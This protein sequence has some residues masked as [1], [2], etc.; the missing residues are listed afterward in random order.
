MFL[1]HLNS[2]KDYDI[3]VLSVDLAV[4]RTK[5]DLMNPRQ[6]QKWDELLCSGKVAAVVMG[7][8][9]ETFTAARE[10]AIE[11]CSIRP[12]RSAAEPWGKRGC[13]HHEIEQL[14]T[15]NTLIQFA[16]KACARMVY[17]GRMA[18]MEHPARPPKPESVSIWQ[19]EET[20][21]LQEAPCS[22]MLTFH[23]SIHGAESK[24]PTTL[25][26]VRMQKLRKHIYKN[27]LGE[28]ES[29]GMITLLGKD[30]KGK[31]RT[32]RAKEYPP[33]LNK[34][35]AKTISEHVEDAHHFGEETEGGAPHNEWYKDFEVAFDPY[36]ADME[37]HADYKREKSKE[38]V[39][40]D[41][42]ES[43]IEHLAQALEDS[44]PAETTKVNEQRREEITI[45]AEEEAS[46][47]DA[48]GLGKGLD[49]PRD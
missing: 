31:F 15:S 27:Q 49:S 32:A 13:K 1:E 9:C 47:E 21:I 7:P 28:E 26:T 45:E 35:I 40:S 17:T 39:E 44:T 33:S 6:R 19:V 11:G 10:N 46:S 34:A 38:A 48:L 5:C 25:L 37:M 42:D 23:Q 30:E 41:S 29:K 8:P 36:S 16:L 3:M 43:W 20:Q 12:I 18:L 4:D 22:D 2:G 24:K 14:H